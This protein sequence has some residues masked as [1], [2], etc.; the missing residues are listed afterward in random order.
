MKKRATVLLLVLAMVLSFA[1]PAM[2]SSDED[3][4]TLTALAEQD[5]NYAEKLPADASKDDKMT[6]DVAIAYLL[7]AAGM[8]EAQLGIYPDDYAGMADSL[9]MIGDD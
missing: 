7:R 6:W 2:A 1:T 5:E 3:I 8:P 4:M 9:G